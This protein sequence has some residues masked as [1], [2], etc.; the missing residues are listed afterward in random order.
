MVARDTEYK[1]YEMTDYIAKR[2]FDMA[3]T[4]IKDMMSKGETAQRILTAVYNYYR[5]LLHCAI[6]NISKG[7]PRRA[8]L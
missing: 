8:L 3:L 1:V 5:R 6:S 2:K 7:S 4:V